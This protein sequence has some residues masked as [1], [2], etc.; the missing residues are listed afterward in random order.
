MK[1]V[2]KVGDPYTK[3]IYSANYYIIDE[4]NYFY[5]GID[6]IEVELL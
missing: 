6:I 5:Y 3:P 4:K 2:N 1:K